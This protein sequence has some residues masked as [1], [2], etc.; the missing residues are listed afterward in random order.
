MREPDDIDRKILAELR[1]NARINHSQLGAIV[2]LSRNA[3]RLRTERLE[4]DGWIRGYT[5]MEPAP[6]PSPRVSATMLV[7]RS[8]RMRGTD[9]IMT[10]RSIPEVVQC[11]V[12]AGELDLIVRVEA[13]DPERIREVWRQMA[14][15]PGVRDIT[16]ALSLQ[17]PIEKR[18][19][20]PAMRAVPRVEPPQQW[21]ASRRTG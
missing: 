19:R 15:L 1:V 3:V 9:V 10:L 20:P 8:D 7:Y 16:T 12:V 2:R 18:P 11:D 13:A 21:G 17:T 5:I 4:R 14:E 6:E